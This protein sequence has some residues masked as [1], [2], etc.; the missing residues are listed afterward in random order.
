MEI[1]KKVTLEEK[2]KQIPTGE[3]FEVVTYEIGGRSFSK[4]E[5]AQAYL[6]YLKRSAIVENLPSIEFTASKEGNSYVNYYFVRDENELNALQEHFE[7]KNYFNRSEIPSGTQLPLWVIIHRREEEY[8]RGYWETIYTIEPHNL[9]NLKELVEH[10]SKV[11]DH[12]RVI[13]L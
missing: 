8:E 3:T 13:V 9:E 11:P 7:T 5:D 6:Q 4:V 10:L 12:T 2:T 1:I